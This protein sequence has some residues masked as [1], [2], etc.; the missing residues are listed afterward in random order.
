[1]KKSYH[2]KAEPTAD[3]IKACMTRLGAAAVVADIGCSPTRR[4]GVADDWWANWLLRGF[5]AS[6]PWTGGAGC[7]QIKG[8]GQRGI[9]CRRVAT[10]RRCGGRKQ[11]RSLG[12]A[13]NDW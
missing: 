5:P 1:M 7:A 3:A 12:P 2:S 10:S 8:F 4:S 13:G 6:L 9:I 11:R